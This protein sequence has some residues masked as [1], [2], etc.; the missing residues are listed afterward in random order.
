MKHRLYEGW[1]MARDE[2]TTDQKRD[3]DA[4][5]KVCESCKQLAEADM[6]VGKTFASVHM[7]EPMPGFVRRWKVR[8]SE[9]RVRAHRRQTSLILGV[10]SFGVTAL[11][12][13][14][15]LQTILVLI[16][17][18]D[19]LFDLADVLVEWISILGV[20][21]ELV[22]TFFST[23]FSTVPLALSF[24]IVVVLIGM[25]ILWGYSLKRL[26]YLP[27]KERSMK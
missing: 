3:L 27:S 25:G 8:L 19:I 24:L 15:L 20:I 6:A 16:S 14:L 21:G 2:L 10:L 13:P 12:L 23:L 17:P 26:G 18:E 11:F 4:H 7:H 9:E 1:I 5:L 22:V